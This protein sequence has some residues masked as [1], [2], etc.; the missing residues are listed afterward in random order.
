VRYRFGRH[1][2]RHIKN[3]LRSLT[4]STTSAEKGLR[5]PGLD[6][7]G[8]AG[9]VSHGMLSCGPVRHGRWGLER[10]GT[11]RSVKVR[12]VRRGREW[13]GR[14]WAAGRV[15]K[16]GVWRGPAR[17]A[18]WGAARIGLARQAGQVRLGRD[19]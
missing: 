10:L 8:A 9:R 12:Q 2:T 13:F 18:W 17:Q 3:L 4:L 6:R 7:L 11:V 14:V 1:G 15:W 5:S 19:G 16:G